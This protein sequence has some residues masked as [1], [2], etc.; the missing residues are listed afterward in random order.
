MLSAPV[1][2][3]TPRLT[4]IGRAFI[5]V[6]EKY[7]LEQGRE[8]KSSGVLESCWA[9][10]QLGVRGDVRVALVKGLDVV[11]NPFLDDAPDEPTI[12]TVREVGQAVGIIHLHSPLLL[13][14]WYEK[15]QSE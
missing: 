2:P 6:D 4:C 7:L 1:M 14:T 12:I 10:L 9:H 8:E 3:P 11:A 5:S 13:S 15:R